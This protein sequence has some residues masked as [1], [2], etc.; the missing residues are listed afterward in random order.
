[1]SMRTAVRSDVPMIRNGLLAAPEVH[2]NG[3]GR[4][5]RF[6]VS[7]PTVHLSSDASKWILKDDGLIECSNDVWSIRMAVNDGASSV[8]MAESTI[9]AENRGKRRKR[10]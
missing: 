9:S 10:V 5:I 6:G 7:A 2:C 1:M 4:T 8:N 3:Y